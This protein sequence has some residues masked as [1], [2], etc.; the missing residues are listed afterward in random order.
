MYDISLRLALFAALL[1]VSGCGKDPVGQPTD[2]GSGDG[3]VGLV[4]PDAVVPPDSKGPACTKNDQCNGGVCLE[5]N[6]CASAEQVCG[7]L[8]CAAG[9]KCFANACVTPGKLCTSAGDCDPGQYCE[10]TLGPGGG[11]K[12][13]GG[14]ATPDAGASSDAGSGGPVCLQPPPLA[15]RCLDLPARCGAVPTPGCLPTC[16]YKPPVGKLTAKKKWWW[17]EGSVKEF[18]NHVDVWSTPVVGRLTDTN[19]DGKV[20]ELDPPNIIFVSGNGEGSQCAAKPPACL[21]GVLRVLDGATGQ[22]IWSLRKPGPGTTGF[23]ALTMALG[24]V[25]RD[26]HLEIVAVDSNGHI[27]LIDYTGKL[28]ATSDKP[29]PEAIKGD[30]T[31]NTGFGWG[32]G[33]ALADMNG[34]GKVEVAYGR[35]IFTIDGNTIT[36]IGAGTHGAAVGGTRALSAFSDLD[37]DGKQELLGG[38]A[39]YRYDGKT[40]TDL[41]YNAALGDGYPAVADFNGDGKPEVVLLISTGTDKGKLAI[42]EGKTG[43]ILAGPFLLPGTGNGGPPTVADFDGDG[44]PEIGVAKAD[45]YSVTKVN[46]AATNAADKLKVLWQQVNHDFSSSVT[47]STVFDFEGDGAAEVIY[48]DECFIWVYDGKTGDV[49]FA[50][51]TTSFTGTEAALVADVDGDGRAE[52]VMMANR[53][54]PTNWKCD[55]EPWTSPDPVLGRPAWVPPTGRTAWSGITVFGDK[56]NSWVGTRTLWNQHSY[57]VSNI[58]DSRDGACFA[59]ENQYGVIPKLEKTN[60]TVK[61]LN[62]FRQNVQDKG[63]FDAPDA[64]IALRVDC[65]NGI[66]GTT[67]SMTLRATLRN[68]GLALLPDGVKIGFYVVETGGDRLLGEQTTTSM[69]FPGQAVELTYGTKAADTVTSKSSFVAKI[70]IDPTNPTFHECRDDNNTSELAKNPCVLQ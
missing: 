6:C 40:V 39:A 13:D 19:C 26:G 33:L 62:N 24:D 48:N 45:Y 14:A 28:L 3:D 64:A 61:W 67:G 15:G 10:P 36:L 18:K 7:K 52:M 16:E 51:P 21:T 42:L 46:L 34:D 32:G 20:N 27:V 41:W 11:T 35:S 60:Y 65:E 22:E 23:A 57:H 38:N 43:N 66:E 54:S 56:A 69:L 50:H 17:G 31:V 58:C 30:G 53:A 55:I 4:F 29:I 5:G 9:S 25:D 49:K 68:L 44:K 12:A 8:C 1:S 2:G 70:I 63:I 37:G 59:A 47:G